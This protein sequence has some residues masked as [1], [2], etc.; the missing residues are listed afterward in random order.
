MHGCRLPA[1]L[2][3]AFLLAPL[4]CQAAG[5]ETQTVRMLL[6][7]S[8]LSDLAI[9]G[10]VSQLLTL[11]QDGSGES[12]YD[13]G[14]TESAADQTVLT[15]NANDAWDL[16][17]KLGGAWS[18]P[19]VYDKAEDDL[20][21]R[22]TNTPTGTIQNGAN[23]YITLAGTDT[24]ILSHTAGVTDDIV[25]VQTRVLLDWTQDVPGAYSITVVYTLVVHVP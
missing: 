12:A 1:H 20:R 14:H 15:L 21:I 25:D 17:A 2:L 4:I 19:G 22:I 6:S 18:C 23:N 8:R 16:S 24:A 10:D 13:V 3:L 9:S 7:V 11:T 5:A